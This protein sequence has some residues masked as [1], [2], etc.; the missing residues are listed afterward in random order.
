M[1]NKPKRTVTDAINERT[2]KN[3][4]AYI[5]MFALAVGAFFL[6]FSELLEIAK[7]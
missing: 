5:I 7:H 4:I 1:D 3:T 2:R 6:I